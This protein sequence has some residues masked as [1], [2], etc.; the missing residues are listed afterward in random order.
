LSDLSLNDHALSDD[1]TTKRF[2]FAEDPDLPGWNRW[3]LAD[4]T[5]FNEF[6]GPLHVRV[7]GGIARVRMVPQRIH[8]NLADNVHGGAIL[9]FIDVALFGA[10][11]GL[12]VLVAGGAQTLDLSTQF[13]AGARYDQPIEAHVELLRE[14]GRFLFM[15]GLVKQDDTVIASFTATVRKPSKA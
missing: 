15:R 12:G 4:E 10:A 14:T 6:L 13:I 8:S 11:R 5:R 1:S 7:E 9:G 2:R 3:Q